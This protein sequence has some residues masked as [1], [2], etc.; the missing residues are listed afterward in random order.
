MTTWINLLPPEILKKR[1]VKRMLSLFLLGLGVLLLLLFFIYLALSFRI[2]QEQQI[3][4]KHKQENLK[5]NSQIAELRIYEAKQAELLRLE[6]VL[7]RAL[8]G[9]FLWSRILNEISMVIPSDV[10]LSSFMGDTAAGIALKGYTFDHPAVAKWMVRQKEI[11]AL[12]KIKLI[13][14]KKSE[15]EKQNVIEFNTTAK[16]GGQK[17]APPE[18]AQ[19]LPKKAK[20]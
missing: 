3:V 12:S 10:W 1:K 8:A 18:K 20:R 13:Y 14:S 5:L 7:K 15:L 17:K 9:R 16:L 2:Y 11:K 19:V 4:S 6:D